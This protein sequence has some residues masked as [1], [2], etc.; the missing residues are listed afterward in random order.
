[1]ASDARRYRCPLPRAGSQRQPQ[2]GSAGRRGR[3]PLQRR[4][5]RSAAKPKDPCPR[6][7][8]PVACCLLPPRSGARRTAE[9]RPYR[10]NPDPLPRAGG[11][12]Q[13][14]RGSAGRR[15]RRPLQRRPERSAAKPKDPCPRPL[16]P[17]A[18]C[19]LPPRSG[20]RRTAESRPYRQN[21]GPL[22][23]AGSQWQP[24]RG[25]AGRRGCRPL[26]RR[27]ERSAAEPKDPFPRPLLPVACCLLPHRSTVRRTAESRPYRQNPDPLPRA[28]GTPP[29]ALRPVPLPC[30][31]ERFWPPLQALILDP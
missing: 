25:S 27:P 22:P 28:G 16:L 10:Q 8:L 29:P 20:V 31:Q 18:C 4:P 17:V 23:R 13:P 11:Q 12:W 2:R 24:Q 6:P 30:K 14:Q 1:M 9:S 15:G 3:R 21:P 5:E 19:L 26:Q 7:L